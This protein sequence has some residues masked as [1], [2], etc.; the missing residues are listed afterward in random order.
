MTPVCQGGTN[1][2]ENLVTSCFSC[3]RGKGGAKPDQAAPNENDRL[4]LFQEAQEQK[5]AFEQIQESI[6]RRKKMKDLVTNVYCEARNRPSVSSSVIGTLLG[7]VDQHGHEPVFNW[8]EIAATRLKP[9]TPDVDFVRYI[10]GIRRRMIERKEIPS[11][12]L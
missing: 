1:D 7:F 4:R 11:E 8:I 5:R 9:N 3:N 12:P 2:I 6:A 10:C